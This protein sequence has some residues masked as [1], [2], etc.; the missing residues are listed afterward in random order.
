M[1]AKL[2]P[3]MHVHVKLVSAECMSSYAAQ[4]TCQDH[5]AGDKD[6]QDNLGHLHPVYETWEQLWLILQAQ[7][8]APHMRTEADRQSVHESCKH[9]WKRA[10]DCE[11]ASKEGFLDSKQSGLYLEDGLELPCYDCLL[12]MY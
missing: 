7:H 10:A 11:G 9:P 12:C 3:Y 6:Q 4:S 5:L 1:I 8:N 2:Q